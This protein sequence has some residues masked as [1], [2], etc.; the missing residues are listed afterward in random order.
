MWMPVL[1][2]RTLCDVTEVGICTVQLLR[3]SQHPN[4]SVKFDTTRVMDKDAYS[5]KYETQYR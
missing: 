5:S 3:D 1:S 4:R 2:H